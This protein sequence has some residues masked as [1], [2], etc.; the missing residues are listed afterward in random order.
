VLEATGQP[1]RFTDVPTRL[2]TVGGGGARG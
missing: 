2:S 1:L